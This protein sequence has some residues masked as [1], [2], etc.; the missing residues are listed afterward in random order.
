MF[1]IIFF[2]I[3]QGL[4]EWLPISSQGNLVLAMVG[5]F[6]Y[7]PEKA[8][9]L[10]LFL[11]LGTL[12]VALVYFRKEIREILIHFKNNQDKVIPFLIV[13]SLV[14]GL[15]GLPFFLLLT[16]PIWTGEL[17]IA[18]TGLFLIITGVLQKSAISKE[19]KE[20]K[21]IS[22]KDSLL[23]GV[24]QGFSIIPGLSRSGITI[25]TLLFRSYKA[26][27][28][29]KLSFL[30]SIP[31]VLMAQIGV[32]LFQGLPAITITEG[33]AGLSSAFLSGMLSIHL[34][35]KLARRV[36]FW[37]FCIVLGIV[38]LIPLFFLI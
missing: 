23:V 19:L 35:L 32:I 2:G 38:A 20:E 6:G 27:T 29:L 17:L 28:A 26:E 25:S 4:L 33:I 30:M 10:S 9:S 14:S 31:A 8:I 37:L 12:L 5:I 34:F 36:K 18:L 13:S 21:N 16:T 22:I 11:H 24:A 3:L 1:E 7:Q 15:V